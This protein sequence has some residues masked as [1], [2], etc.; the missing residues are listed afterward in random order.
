MSFKARLTIT[1]VLAGVGL[2]AVAPSA[3]GQYFG[4]N[5]VQYE[6]FDFEVLKTEHF[7]IYYYPEVEVELAALM[8]E[9]W[10]ARLSRLLNHDLSGRQALIL[11][12]AHPHFQQS[13]ALA[14]TLDE[15]TQGVTE[16]L[17]R[18]IVL[19]FLGPLAETDHVIGHPGGR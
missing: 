11:Y 13:N 18:R 15:S 5:K 10:Y 19:P 3:H 4:R 1:A 7:D 8:A 17:K 9:R 16:L 6:N 14:G 12:A 2:T